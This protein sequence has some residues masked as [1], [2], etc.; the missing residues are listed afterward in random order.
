LERFSLFVALFNLFV[1]LEVAEELAPS[2]ELFMVDGIVLLRHLHHFVHLVALN[3]IEYLVEREDL[4]L[5]ANDAHSFCIDEVDH[6]HIHAQMLD[7]LTALQDSVLV[8]VKQLILLLHSLDLRGQQEH[9]RLL[10]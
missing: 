9:L 6:F 10:T 2:D 4:V 3:L 1:V 8:L 7:E 5:L